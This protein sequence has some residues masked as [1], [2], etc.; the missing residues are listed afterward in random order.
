MNATER[1]STIDPNILLFVY[2]IKRKTM[3]RIHTLSKEYV[4]IF[5]NLEEIVNFTA[6]LD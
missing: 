5:F 2:D 6:S 1:S 4:I 3:S